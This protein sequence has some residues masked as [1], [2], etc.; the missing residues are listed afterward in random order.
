MRGGCI[1]KVE[2]SLI[3]CVTC[4][5]EIFVH[6]FQHIKHLWCHNGGSVLQVEYNQT[7]TYYNYI[8]TCPKGSSAIVMKCVIQFSQTNTCLLAASDIKQQATDGKWKSPLPSMDSLP[9]IDQ[10]CPFYFET[11]WHC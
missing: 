7:N 5:S 1:S 4:L 6:F 8:T 10:I 9:E 3:V 2:Q 11:N